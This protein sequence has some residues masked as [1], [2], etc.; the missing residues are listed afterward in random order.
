MDILLHL[1]VL[2]ALV[3]I[4][5]IVLSAWYGGWVLW[6]LVLIFFMLSSLEIAV[7]LKGLH[8]QPS[9]W[10]IQVGGLITFA[11]AYLYK[12]EY[13]GFTIVLLLFANLLLMVFQYPKTGPLDAFGNVTAVLYLANFVFFYLIR[14][15]ENGF[16]WLLLLLTATWAS[17][18]FAYF[19][20]RV[21][22]KH[23]LAPLLSP[24]KTIEGAVGGV[25]GSSLTA[26]AFV[27]LV[28]VL[29]LWPVVLLGAL[30]GIA[31]LLGD[32]VESALKRQA[33]VKDSGNIIPGHGGM[34]DRFDSLLF[35]A[36]LVYY[37][38]NLLII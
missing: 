3:G 9:A 12:D 31:S 33:G 8:L 26:L 29:P 13:I 4:P 11:S 7:I 25:I 28:P 18:T 15:L 27:K 10:L 5:V 24:K 6:L 14:G 19:V 22:G 36:P 1:R 37:V 38:V 34:L 20:G 2:S 23:K 16:V 35:T 17:D 32:L 30:I 21:L